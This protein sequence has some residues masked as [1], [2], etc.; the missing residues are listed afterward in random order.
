MSGEAGSLTRVRMSSPG[1][2]S[3]NFAHSYQVIGTLQT[4]DR[5]TLR[6][7]LTPGA[8]GDLKVLFFSFTYTSIQNISN[9]YYKYIITYEVYIV[10]L[11]LVF[12]YLYSISPIRYSY[13]YRS[14]S[15]IL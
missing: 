7:A 10:Y 15:I 3:T 13:C 9:I 4:D 5:L 12:S 1:A 14:T 11:V 6:T 2:L 8:L